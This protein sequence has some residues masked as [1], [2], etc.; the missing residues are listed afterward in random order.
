MSTSLQ[1]PFHS[2][3]WSDRGDFVLIRVY[4]CHPMM[5]CKYISTTAARNF[6]V[7]KDKNDEM[8]SQNNV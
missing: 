8:N 5:T 7:Q 4:P 1:V 2:F 3:L 6:Y